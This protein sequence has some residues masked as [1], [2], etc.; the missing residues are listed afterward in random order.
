L[1]AVESR[2][3]I[4][5]R[6]STFQ[7]NRVTNVSNSPATCLVTTFRNAGSQLDYFVNYHLG[8]GFSHLFLF[9]DSPSEAIDLR[10]SSHPQ[11]TVFA[12]EDLVS[13]RWQQQGLYGY[14]RE[15]IPR[16]VMARQLLNVQVAVGLA[17]E[18]GFDWIVHI[19]ADDLFYPG[20][21][22]LAEHFLHVQQSEAAVVR[23]W[24]HEAVTENFG[25]R[26]PFG[27][28]NLFKK[29]D[30]LLQPAQV[31]LVRETWGKRPYFNFYNNGK[32]AA[33]VHP[34]LLPRGVH[35]FYTGRQ[36]LDSAGPCILHFACGG[37]TQF[38]DKYT[39]LGPFADHWFG[40]TPIGTRI[41]VHLQCRDVVMRGDRDCAERFFREV[42]MIEDPCLL[43]TL[44]QAA[45]CERFSLPAFPGNQPAAPPVVTAVQVH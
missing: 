33:R 24:N 35:S 30:N 18:Y 39:L 34:Q 8:V 14:L 23:Y 6:L 7:L 13:R 2:A 43:A 40:N 3:L 4:S 5:P 25:T 19:D 32:A 45:I 12:Y 44:L 1:G 21:S 26:D 10:V 15:F 38:L 37:F 16:E 22:T 36:V 20:E 9:P 28:I 41:P 42:F 27:E 29:N 11:V 17:C 31:R